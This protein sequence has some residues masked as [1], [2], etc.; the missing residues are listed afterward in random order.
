MKIAAV[1]TGVVVFGFAVWRLW[2]EDK[3]RDR[4]DR[5]ARIVSAHAEAARWSMDRV[6]D[7][8]GNLWGKGE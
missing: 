7:K 1:L 3:D 4:E 6:P 5:L 2:A 8:Q